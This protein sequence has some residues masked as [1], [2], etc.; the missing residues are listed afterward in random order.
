MAL[1]T[2]AEVRASG[3]IDDH[4]AH[5]AFRYEDDGQLDDEVQKA[6]AWAVGW[7][8]ARVDTEFYT[9][10]TTSDT[11]RDE[12]FKGAEEDMALY[13]LLPR[14]KVRKVLGTHAPLVQ[15]GSD[16]FEALIDDEIPR[17]VEMAI[18]PYATIETSADSPFAL[19]Q[20]AATDDFDREDL[21]SIDVQNAAIIDESLGLVGVAE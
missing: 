1:T 2:I 11:D 7:L 14:L 18:E 13:R 15:E 4:A 9:G 19:P 16:R 21:L 20:I 3:G 8:K 5:R 6:I 10:S 17:H 12:L